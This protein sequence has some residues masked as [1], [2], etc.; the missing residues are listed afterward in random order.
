MFLQLLPIVAKML[1]PQA[2]VDADEAA[3]GPE[4]DVPLELVGVDRPF[5]ED[6]RLFLDTQLGM[7]APRNGN[8]IKASAAV[9]A[10]EVEL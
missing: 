10:A 8:G 3:R 5:T 7:Q 1:M 2:F 4:D 6:D 9:A